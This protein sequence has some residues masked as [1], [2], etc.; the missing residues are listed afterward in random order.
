M[1]IRVVPHTASSSSALILR[2]P[3]GDLVHPH[4]EG[5]GELFDCL[6]AES[7][8]CCYPGIQD[9]QGY[10]FHWFGDLGFHVVTFLFF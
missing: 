1:S 4:A 6:V 5:K 3:A 2:L 10:H 9:R 8:S 7:C